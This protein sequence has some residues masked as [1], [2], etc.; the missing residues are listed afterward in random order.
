LTYVDTRGGISN[1]WSQPLEGGPPKQVTDFKSEEIFSFAR[2]RDGR[3]LALARGV[4]TG[5]VVLI[6]D[7]R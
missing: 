6:S 7:S 1:I 2:S 3:Q 5:D 4:E